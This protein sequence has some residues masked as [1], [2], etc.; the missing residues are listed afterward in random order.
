MRSGIL[1][2]GFTIYNHKIR[3]RVPSGVKV[4]FCHSNGVPTVKFDGF[5][6]TLMKIDDRWFAEVYGCLLLM[7]FPKG[8]LPYP[9]SYF[10]S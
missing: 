10:K 8:G 5:D 1:R 4:F 7:E 6:I 3:V 2:R 9:L